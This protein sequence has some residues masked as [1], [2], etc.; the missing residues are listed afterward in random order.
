MKSRLSYALI[1]IQLEGLPMSLGGGL[2]TSFDHGFNGEIVL[3]EEA[4]EPTPAV[5]VLGPHA[6]VGL[7][8]MLSA[9]GSGAVLGV[10]KGRRGPAMDA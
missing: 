10:G 2:H 6:L 9:I 4:P 1:S 7:M 3:I 8:L 5:P